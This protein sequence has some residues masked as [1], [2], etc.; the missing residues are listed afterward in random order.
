MRKQ[1]PN[2]REKSDQ[3]AA[4]DDDLIPGIPDTLENIA[5]SIVMTP[6][7]KPHEWKFMQ[8]RD[9]TK[10]GAESSDK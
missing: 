1:A 6:P 4:M 2:S 9:A 8:G 10:Q 5:K 3:Q 7:K